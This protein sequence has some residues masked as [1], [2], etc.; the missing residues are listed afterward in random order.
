[1]KECDEGPVWSEVL[2]E[3]LIFLQLDQ[4]PLELLLKDNNS[5][6]QNMPYI[7]PGF[8]IVPIN[9]DGNYVSYFTVE[10]HSSQFAVLQNNKNNIQTTSFSAQ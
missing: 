4:N 2:A 9:Y 7:S 3:I 1:M 8:A 6:F 10:L 5:Y